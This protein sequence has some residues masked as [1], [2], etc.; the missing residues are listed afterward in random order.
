MKKLIVA[1][2][3]AAAAA[4]S[5][6]ATDPNTSV[7]PVVEREFVTGSNIGRKKGEAPTDQ[8]KTYSKET[9]ENSYR[10]GTIGAGVTPRNGGGSAA[11]N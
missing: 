4:A 1:A 3:A 8:I 2:L 6:C 7:E 11:G 9:L 10:T 5:G